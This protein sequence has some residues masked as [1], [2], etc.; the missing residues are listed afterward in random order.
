[1]MSTSTWVIKWKEEGHMDSHV[2]YY[3]KRSVNSFDLPDA[4]RWADARVHA[5]RALQ[6]TPAVFDAPVQGLRV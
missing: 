3:L 1:M 2:G 4:V 5:V 6:W